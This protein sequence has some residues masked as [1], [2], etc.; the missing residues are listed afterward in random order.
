MSND[1]SFWNRELCWLGFRRDKSIITRSGICCLPI[2]LA[3][4][5][6]ESRHSLFMWHQ[7]SLPRF[8]NVCG[9]HLVI[10]FGQNGQTSEWNGFHHCN[11]GRI[12][13]DQN[14]ILLWSDSSCCEKLTQSCSNFARNRF[15][16][17]ALQIESFHMLPASPKVPMHRFKFQKPEFMDRIVT[18]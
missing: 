16:S 5:S 15:L 17:V 2:S 18:S 8:E 12:Y 9:K 13:E 14:G 3:T 6:L 4:E 11:T 10:V 1:T 7:T